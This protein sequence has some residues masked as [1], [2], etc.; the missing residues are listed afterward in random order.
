MNKSTI[1]ISYLKSFNIKRRDKYNQLNNECN[2]KL[3]TLY[4]DKQ[5]SLIINIF[6]LTNNQQ[7]VKKRPDAK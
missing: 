7:S 3:C 5:K 2:G 6:T 1:I 4:K